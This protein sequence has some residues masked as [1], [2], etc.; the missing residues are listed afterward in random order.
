MNPAQYALHAR[1]VPALGEFLLDWLDPKPGERILDV[2]CGDGALT[3]RIADRGA[4]VVGIDSSGAMVEAAR[5][6]GM[7]ARMARA[8]ALAF[9]AEFD[10]VFSNAALHWVSDSE[11]VVRGI[12][13]ALKPG[14]RFVAEFGGFM[15]IAAVATAVRAVLLRHGRRLEDVWTWYFP[16]DEE[17][18]LLLEKHG[19][20][21]E[22][23]ALVPRPTPISSGMEY[24][25]DTFGVR[26][27]LTAAEKAD[28]VDLLRPA[29]CDSSGNWTLDYVRLRLRARL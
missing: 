16:T 8:E 13:K 7:D 1:F 9:E 19:F 26:F 3:R 21:V 24:W 22:E 6:A 5:E 11:S 27:R 18:R 20:A 29:L 28:I 25:L 17:Y 15:N 14:G 12:S 10:G 4:E 23:I 2:G